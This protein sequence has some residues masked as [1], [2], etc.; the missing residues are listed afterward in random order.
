MYNDIKNVYLNMPLKRHKYLQ[1]RLTDIPKEI[2]NEYKLHEKVMLDEYVYLAV[3][4]VIC[5]LP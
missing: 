4:K 5:V 1:I 2:V 3:Y